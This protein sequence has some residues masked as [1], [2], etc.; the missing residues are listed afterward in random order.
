MGFGIFQPYLRIW[1]VGD[2]VIWLFGDYLVIIWWFGD[3]FLIYKRYK[4]LWWRLGNQSKRIMAVMKWICDYN[5]EFRPR[6]GENAGGTNSFWA[7]TTI[8]VEYLWWKKTLGVR[9]DWTSECGKTP[10][11][12]I[13]INR[14][15]THGLWQKIFKKKLEKKYIKKLNI[16]RSHKAKTLSVFSPQKKQSQNG[17][18][19]AKKSIEKVVENSRHEEPGQPQELERRCTN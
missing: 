13:F 5:L 6:E 2:L 11:E 17:S 4:A 8:E 14:W 3:F 15:Q 16:S 1:W 9:G 12:N 10:L 18:Q 7:F 19:L